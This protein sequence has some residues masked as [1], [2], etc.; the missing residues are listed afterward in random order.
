M[1]R[2]IAAGVHE[3]ILEIDEAEARVRRLLPPLDGIPNE[4]LDIVAGDAP[5][6]MV[7]Q[8]SAIGDRLWLHI[9]GRTFLRLTG[10]AAVRIENC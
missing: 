4:V 7:L 8:F 5:F 3:G 9:G 2:S 1:A 10:L 6:D